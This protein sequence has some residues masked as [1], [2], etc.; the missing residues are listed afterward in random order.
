MTLHQCP[1][2][3]EVTIRA[4]DLDVDLRR[5]LDTMGLLPG[6]RITP[7]R[8]T[9]GNLVLCVYD[10]RLAIDMGLAKRITVA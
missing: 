8:A 6:A 5:K 9:H 1:L 7:L 2:G 3:R 4:C 10:G